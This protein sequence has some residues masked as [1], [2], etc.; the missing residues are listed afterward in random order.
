LK[1]KPQSPE[2]QLHS[3][4]KGKNREL[5]TNPTVADRS[6]ASPVTAPNAVPSG[7]YNIPAPS[8]SSANVGPSFED[9]LKKFDCGYSYKGWNKSQLVAICIHRLGATGRSPEHYKTLAKRDLLNEIDAWV[10]QHR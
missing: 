7:S 6:S 5:N 1:R 2:A 4:Q 8:P 10:C 3:S 9:D